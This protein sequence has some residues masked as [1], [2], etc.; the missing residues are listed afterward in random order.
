MPTD[1]VFTK[2]PA[3]GW[4]SKRPSI[5]EDGDLTFEIR[6]APPGGLK[7]ADGTEIYRRPI[8]L[9][10][11]IGDESAQDSA[12]RTQIRDAY[13]AKAQADAAQAGVP[14][15]AI[16]WGEA[17]DARLSSFVCTSFY[18]PDDTD[19]TPQ[20]WEVWCTENIGGKSLSYKVPLSIDMLNPET[21]PIPGINLSTIE[22]PPGTPV[23]PADSYA[24][25]Q[26][27]GIPSL[28]QD[29]KVPA[30]QLPSGLGEGAGGPVTTADITDSTEL[31]RALLRITDEATARFEISAASVDHDHAGVYATTGHGHTASQI[32]D[33][34]E[35]VQDSLANFFQVTGASFTYDDANNRMIVTI[36]GDGGD[37]EKMRDTIGAAIIGLGNIN[38][39]PNDTADTI[40][41]TTT[42]TQNSTDAQLR[43]RSTHTGITPYDAFPQG[44]RFAVSA[45]LGDRPTTSTNVVFD[46]VGPVAPTWALPPSGSF[47]GDFWAKTD[48]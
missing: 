2:V 11:V 46:A 4:F 40:T 43:A 27:N 25:G 5:P 37:P 17:W 9:K 44:T 13:R 20:G 12:V 19:I 22:I 16:Q 42:A 39:V 23:K 24:K 14:F 35:V 26:P 41:I 6:G 29:G 10:A 28:D 32:V 8:I 18:A 38:V 33:F 48:S 30:A 7:R 34:A 45:S 31:G 47:V 21:H 15:N 1:G 3:Y 36:N